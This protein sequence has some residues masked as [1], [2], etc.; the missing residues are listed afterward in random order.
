MLSAYGDQG[1]G[2]VIPPRST[3]IFHIELLK[4]EAGTVEPEGSDEDVDEAT[5]G[6][7][8]GF[9]DE[10]FSEMDTD[11]DKHINVEELANYM[12]KHEGRSKHADSFDIYTAAGEIFQEEDKNKDGLL[13][14][15]ELVTQP[16]KHD[17]L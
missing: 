2:D 5:I 15:D 6:E 16:G 14:Y 7:A 9:T 17:E 8:L 13:S 12:I 11:D 4:L 3:L 10:M 1:F